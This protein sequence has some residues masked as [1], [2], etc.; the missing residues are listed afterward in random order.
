[1]RVLQARTS[2]DQSQDTLMVLFV[3]LRVLRGL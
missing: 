2:R 3:I 1:M